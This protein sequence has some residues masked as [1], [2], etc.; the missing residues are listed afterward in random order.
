M[1]MLFLPLHVPVVESL[2]SQQR[3]K[4]TYIAS[5]R[6]VYMYVYVY[7]RTYILTEPYV[8]VYIHTH[9]YMYIY[10]YPPRRHINTCFAGHRTICMCV[11]VYIHIY[12]K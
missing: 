11:N 7:I 6:K 9:M 4:F 1:L 8:Y 12:I 10:I 2:I 3:N 5:R